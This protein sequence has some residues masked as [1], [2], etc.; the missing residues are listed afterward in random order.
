M[1]EI[2]YP[3]TAAPRP[4]LLKQDLRVVVVA[5]HHETLVLAAL[6][7]PIAGGV[8]ALSVLPAHGLLRKH[9]TLQVARTLHVGT[10]STV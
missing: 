3:V 7:A 1:M 6:L 8:Y 9:Q 5:L 4:V 2:R 10:V